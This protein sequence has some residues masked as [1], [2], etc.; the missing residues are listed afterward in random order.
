MIEYVTG[1]I[2]HSG[3]DALVNPVNCVGVM[4]KGLALQFKRAFPENFDSY[5]ASCASGHLVPGKLC[6]QEYPRD[7]ASPRF[8]VNLPTKRHWK[9]KSLLE[10]VKVGLD[11]LVRFVVIEEVKSVAIPPLGCGL[12]GLAWPDVRALI[13]AAFAD[14]PAAFAGDPMF[15]GGKF[16]VER[17]TRESIEVD[18]ENLP[19]VRVLVYE[20]S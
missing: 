10:D 12:G 17:G 7:G 18:L 1:N 5:R 3:A 15:A 9:D 11:A 4:G 19:D 8:I 20:P 2:L 16:L 14:M 13:E 6:V